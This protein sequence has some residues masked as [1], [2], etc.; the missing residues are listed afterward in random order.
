[1]LL[2]A[3]CVLDKESPYTFSISLAAFLCY[4]MRI[5]VHMPCEG[6]I[7]SKFAPDEYICSLITMFR[8]IVNVAVDVGVISMNY[9]LFTGAFGTLSKMMAI[10][11]CLQLC[12]I[13]TK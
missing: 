8:V 9:I 5:G 10:A 6:M 4:D 1:M 7:C 13:P 2:L 3:P 12:T 11:A